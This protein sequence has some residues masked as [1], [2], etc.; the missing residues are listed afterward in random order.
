MKIDGAVLSA[1][2]GLVEE[3]RETFVPARLSVL[4]Y[5]YFTK[6]ALFTSLQRKLNLTSGN[7]SSHLRK[8]QQAGLVKVSKQFVELKPTTTV[9][10]TSAGVERVRIQV[11]RMRDIV[12][13]V[14]EDDESMGMKNG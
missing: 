8:L 7:L 3:D 1:L 9:S 10:I 5:L 6:S 2:A 12:S 13:M 11:Q 4:V 14:V